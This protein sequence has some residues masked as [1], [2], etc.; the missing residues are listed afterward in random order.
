MNKPVISPEILAKLKADVVRVETYPVRTFKGK[1]KDLV[2]L[3]LR[4]Y[5]FDE[6]KWTYM[7]EKGKRIKKNPISFSHWVNN[8]MEYWDK[9]K[10]PY[11]VKIFDSG[12]NYVQYCNFVVKEN[13]Y[14]H[15]NHL[16]T[17]K[18]YDF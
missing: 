2:P 11:A 10:V 6:G 5:S 1:D 14:E 13:G 9:T 3:S 4:I 15:E 17:R 16:T 7:N 12:R 18:V 8:K